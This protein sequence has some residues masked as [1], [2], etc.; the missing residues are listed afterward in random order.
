MLMCDPQ[1][2]RWGLVGSVWVMRVYPHEWLGALLMNMSEF[3]LY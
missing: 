3:S 1:G 2:W